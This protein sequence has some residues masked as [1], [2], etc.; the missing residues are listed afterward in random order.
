MALLYPTVP[1]L[2]QVLHMKTKRMWLFVL[3]KEMTLSWK[4]GNQ[5]WPDPQNPEAKLTTVYTG[6]DQCPEVT[7]NGL[8][9]AD[10][11]FVEANFSGAATAVGGPAGALFGVNYKSK[12]VGRVI[13][14]NRKYIRNG[15]YMGV[16]SWIK[17]GDF[18]NKEFCFDKLVNELDPF[19]FDEFTKSNMEFVACSFNCKTGEPTYF[20]I[21]DIRDPKQSEMLRSSGSLPCLS[22]PVEID[23][24]FYLDGGVI[25]SIPVKEA[26]RRGYDKIIVVCTRP[27][28]YRKE[29]KNYGYMKWWYK[30]YP[31]IYEAMKERH[32]NY[33]ENV[34]FII[35]EE[36]KGHIYV[37]RPSELIKVGRLEKDVNKITEMYNLG[38]KDTENRLKD[39]KKYIG[40]K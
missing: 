24:S 14:Y 3:K 6:K 38:I 34:E 18:M 15:N 37:M 1:H 21:T 26:I 31:K 17:T 9:D 35:D 25:D 16:K 8:C 11:T 29:K 22:K 27:E 19:D 28:D 33:N 20:D 7:L 32:T 4:L 40:I 30:K 2:V 10:K 36:K 23:D 13:R 12:Q 39:I 5:V